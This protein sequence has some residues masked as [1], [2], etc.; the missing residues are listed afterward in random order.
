MDKGHLIAG[1]YR[2]LELVGSGSMGIV[3]QARDERLDRTVAIKQLLVRPGRT[4]EQA[5]QARRRAMR[6]ARI[7][8]RLQHHNAVVVYDVAE[9]Q[10]DPC[11]VLEYLPSR[12]LSQVISERG[13]LPP[14]EAAAVGAEVAVALAAAHAAGIIHRDIKPGNVLI[15]HSGTA[16]ITDFGIAR[17]IDDGTM[18]Q[19]TGTLAGTPAYLAPEVARGDE[20]SRASDVFSLGATLYHAVEGEPPF[21]RAEN[22]LALLYAVAGGQVRPMS[23][24][25]PLTPVITSLLRPDPAQRPSM[26]EAAAALS[27]VA[28]GAKVTALPPRTATRTMSPAMPTTPATPVTQAPPPRPQ[29]IPPTPPRPQPAI[30]PSTPQ[31]PARGMAQPPKK[32]FTGRLVAILVAVLVLAGVVTAVVIA[33]NQPDTPAAGATSTTPPPPASSTSTSTATTTTTKPP[34][35]QSNG[36]VNYQ[37]AGQLVIDYYN[38]QPDVDAMWAKLTPQVQQSFGDLNAFKAYWAQYPDL[39]A[40]NARGVTPNGDGSVNVPVDVTYKDGQ[41]QHKVLKVIAQGTTLLIA[42]DGH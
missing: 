17:A 24:A 4:E 25:G 33:A 29:R 36:V 11:L 6:E 27:E 13:S 30:L 2:L 16:K 38:G 19:S 8:A 12:S 28:S 5:D 10:G 7:A 26:E 34:A 20:T 14:E 3:W 42:S 31:T 35:V 23:K 37:L 41:K 39:S 15:A 40:R 9:H 21:G 22:P 32:V 1:R 18:T